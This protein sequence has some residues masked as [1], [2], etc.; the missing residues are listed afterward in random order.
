MVRSKASTPTLSVKCGSTH[1]TGR[2][3]SPGDRCTSKES[4]QRHTR[5]LST[6]RTRMGTEQEEFA[7]LTGLLATKVMVYEPGP[8]SADSRLPHTGTDSTC[9]H[10]STLDAGRGMLITARSRDGGISTLMAP[11]QWIHGAGAATQEAVVDDQRPP[12]RHTLDKGPDR[13]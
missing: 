13:W 6:S 12:G 5:G 7:R 3:A 4:G 10:Q 8:S 11:G 9:L 2:E 1:E